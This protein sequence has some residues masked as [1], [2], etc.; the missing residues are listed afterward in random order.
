MTES[1][2]L[3]EVLEHGYTGHHHQQRVY[4]GDGDHGAP[5]GGHHFGVCGPFIASGSNQVGNGD[6][7]HHDVFLI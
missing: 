4:G 5:V 2:V 3:G 7:Q 1:A 6:Q